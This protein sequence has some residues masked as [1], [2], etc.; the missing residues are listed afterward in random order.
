MADLSATGAVVGI[1]VGMTTAPITAGLV[2]TPPV[3][4]SESDLSPVRPIKSPGPAAA[5]TV[6]ACVLTGLRAGL[7]WDLPG[8]LAFTVGLA[9]LA[10]T[11][12]YWRVLP[13]RIVYVTW[14]CGM[15]GLL[16]AAVA[17]DRWSSFATAA[18]AGAILFV[19][20]AGLHLLAPS[21][22]AFG[23]ARMVGPIGSCLGWWGVPTVLVGFVGSFVLA[24]MTSLVLLAAGR[25]HRRSSVALGAYLAAGTAL[26]VWSW[27]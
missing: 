25:L 2:A 21:S 4:R 3:S 6:A 5:V 8:M 15:A 16:L 12:V 9:V 27:H 23:D 1:A 22:L 13:K 14:A 20:L 18:G 24:A 26:T 10:M 7:H 19:L 11:D 17:E